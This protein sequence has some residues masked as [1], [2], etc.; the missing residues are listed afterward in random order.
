MKYAISSESMKLS[1]EKTIK[2]GVSAIEL[3]DRASHALFCVAREIGANNIAVVCGSGNNGGD[4]YALSLK[5][6]DSGRQ[7]QVYGKIPKTQSAMYYYDI[8]MDKYS[9]RF[10][11]I[12]KMQSLESFDLVV[13]CLLGIGIIGQ[14]SAEYASYIDKINTGKYIVSCDIPSGLNSDNGKKSPVSVIAN[15]TIAVQSYK[16]GHFLADGKDVCGKLEICDIGIEIFGK[17]YFIVDSK[18][19]KNCFSI[20]LNNSHKGDYGRWNC[21]VF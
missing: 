15:R 16:T 12:E 2:S 20:K 6:L 19:V 4:G 5:L 17:K 11:P 1:D 10:C 3:M 18:F 8:L 7:V 13:D 21:C 9:E 14:L